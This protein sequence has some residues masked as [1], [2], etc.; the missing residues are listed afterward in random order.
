MKAREPSHIIKVIQGVQEKEFLLHCDIFVV[1]R[2]ASVGVQIDLQGISRKHLEVRIEGDTVVVRDLVSANGTFLD[3]VRL[4]GQVPT[5]LRKGQKLQIA[6]TLITLEIYPDLSRLKNPG[7]VGESVSVVN[8]RVSDLPLSTSGGAENQVKVAPES[9]IAEPIPEAEPLRAPVFLKDEDSLQVEAS[10]ES[11]QHTY[12]EKM[13]E[14]K[15]K[16]LFEDRSKRVKAEQRALE[17]V[18]EV[19]NE[20]ANEFG[21]QPA[22]QPRKSEV[23]HGA[24]KLR[25]ADEQSDA[26]VP[27]GEAPEGIELQVEAVS[28]PERTKARRLESARIVA[29]TLQLNAEYDGAKKRLNMVRGDL[30]KAQAHKDQLISDHAQLDVKMEVQNQ[31]LS[32]LG[33]EV[34]GLTSNKNGLEQELAG[35]HA[36]MNLKAQ[37]LRELNQSLTEIHEQLSAAEQRRK[38]AEDELELA[39]RRKKETEE[40]ADQIQLKCEQGVATAQEAT[41][42]L[43]ELADKAGSDEVAARIQLSE[44][45]A[46]AQAQL[47]ELK[48]QSLAQRTEEELRSRAQA[49]EH[50]ARSKTIAAEHE[51]RSRLLEGEYLVRGRELETKNEARVCELEAKYQ[52]R[53]EELEA[54]HQARVAVQEA[55]YSAQS[56]AQTSEFEGRSR[57]QTETLRDF[58][59]RTLIATADLKKAEEDALAIRGKALVDAENLRQKELETLKVLQ[60]SVAEVKAMLAELQSI[61][62][63]EKAAFEAFE[64]ETH[65][66]RLKL[67]IFVEELEL[68][69]ATAESEVSSRQLKKQELEEKFIH[70]K[71]KSDQDQAAAGAETARLQLLSQ[72]SIQQEAEARARIEQ[73]AFRSAGAE[74]TLQELEVRL[75]ASTEE[76]RIAELEAAAV[77]ERSREESRRMKQA[78][79]LEVKTHS[80]DQRKKANSDF[81]EAAKRM[82]ADLAQIR[83]QE[84]NEIQKLQETEKNKARAFRSA[85]LDELVHLAMHLDQGAPG[86]QTSDHLRSEMERILDGRSAS[87]MTVEVATRTKKFWRKV[88]TAGAVPTAAALLFA[89][90]PESVKNV[91]VSIHSYVNRSLASGQDS[92]G[93]F[94]EQ[95]KQRGLKFQPAQDRNYRATYTDNLLYL[96]GYAELKLD[97][98]LQKEWTLALKEFTTTTLGLSDRVVVE[99]LPTE[100][101]FLKELTG[102]RAIINEQYKDSGIQRMNDLEK[103]EVA[104]MVELLKTQENYTQFRDFEKKFYESHR[105]SR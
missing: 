57:L 26:I 87:K 101:S 36:R 39:I 83:L 9:P 37:K 41:D 96:E 42:R 45:K 98:E 86:L 63:R 2:E 75:A 28:S 46:H 59:E 35:L 20:S 94:L 93:V 18:N 72:Q 7:E 68:K 49:A 53:S 11:S 25:A 12:Q 24:D 65:V 100:S 67:Q 29:E 3:G 34:S 91:Q 13:L 14:E 48:A 85:Q 56:L 66:K 38:M 54:S 102:I 78:V 64:A 97:E 79:E 4:K 6:G 40:D 33:L 51:A 32:A 105:K 44:L 88:A 22:R 80:E 27:R 69:R 71:K 21:A 60:A 61:H 10:A 92:G 47:S 15:F 62:A 1:G 95:M 23:L 77:R 58:S 8:T 17:A 55:G 5:T 81:A 90:F 30:E 73:L 82:E 16:L 52:L 31:L 104:K 43:R 89:L 70:L 50:L 19:A 99:L 84:M 74:R 76:V 103:A